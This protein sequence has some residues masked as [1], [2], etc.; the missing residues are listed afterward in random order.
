MKALLVAAAFAA[1]ILPAAAS[2]LPP[3]ATCGIKGVVQSVDAETKRVSVLVSERTTVKETG[4]GKPCEAVSEPVALEYVFRSEEPFP[5]AAGTEIIAETQFVGDE[6]AQA[7]AIF[8][9]KSAD[10]PAPEEKE[11]G[12]QP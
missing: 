2:Q 6:F 7:D 8:N 11:E 12:Q 4:F 10:A 9:V 1:F 3:L 5:F